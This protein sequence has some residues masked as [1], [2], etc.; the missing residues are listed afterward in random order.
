ME[1]PIRPP[2]TSGGAAD[3][4]TLGHGHQGVRTDGRP[5]SIRH[6]DAVSADVR[7]QQLRDAEQIG[8]GSTEA[9]VIYQRNAVPP[10]LIAERCGSSG[11]DPQDRMI[12]HQDRL[13]QRLNSDEWLRS[14]GESFQVQDHARD[15][16][17]NECRSKTSPVL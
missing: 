8:A 1:T 10:P 12:K 5:F 2:R 7:W 3:L 11:G 9:T 16:Q 15:G 6:H 13:A 14:L 4:D 17:G